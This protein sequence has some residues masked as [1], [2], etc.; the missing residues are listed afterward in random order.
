ME[1]AKFWKLWRIG[2][3]EEMRCNRLALPAMFSLLPIFIVIGFLQGLSIALQVAFVNVTA[4][5]VLQLATSG[6]KN[7]PKRDGYIIGA[8]TF[9]LFNLGILGDSVEGV[10]LALVLTA[11]MLCMYEL[12]WFRL[13]TNGIERERHYFM[14]VLSIAG[15]LY[16]VY[17]GGVKPLISAVFFT[18]IILAGYIAYKKLS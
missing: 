8:F 14:W 12:I 16:L 7:G 5:S 15:I 9:S 4:M 10:I 1:K 11:L 2:G 6:Y 13:W 3:G 17:L 18:V